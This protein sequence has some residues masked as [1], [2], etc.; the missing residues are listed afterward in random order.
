MTSEGYVYVDVRTQAEFESGHPAGAY[1]VPFMLA[2]A[3]GMLANP[4]FVQVVTARFALDAKIVVGCKS[5]QRSARA[6]QA[7]ALAGFTAV[8]DQRAGFSGAT[9]PFGQVKEKGWLALGLPSEEGSPSE[10][11]YAALTDSSR[12]RNRPQPR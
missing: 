2:S 5:G 8:L 7:L 11:A 4:D 12:D 9:T 10:R 6:A 1:N 3:G